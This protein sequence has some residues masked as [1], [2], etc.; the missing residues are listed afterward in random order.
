MVEDCIFCKIIAGEIPSVT[1]YEDNEVLAI[2]DISQVT[3]GHTLV[4]PKEH[5]RNLLAMTADESA[6]LFARVPKLANQVKTAMNAEGMNIIANNEAVGGQSVFH[7]HVHLLP[8]Y[9]GD[10]GPDFINVPTHDYNLTE[11]ADAIKAAAL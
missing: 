2:L 6:R 7:T 4:L 10:E 8:R 5:H 3:K 1:V 9:T 11:I